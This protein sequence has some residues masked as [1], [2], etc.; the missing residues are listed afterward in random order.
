MAQSVRILFK[1]RAERY[2]DAS[3]ALMGVLPSI[4]EVLNKYDLYHFFVS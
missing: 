4:I 1:S 3:V 2:F